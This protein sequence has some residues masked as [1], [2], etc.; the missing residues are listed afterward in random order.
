MVWF[1]G[2]SRKEEE[3]VRVKHGIVISMTV[4]GIKTESCDA[5]RL[6]CSKNDDE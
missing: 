3:C 1:D 6:S 5:K 4:E 2:E